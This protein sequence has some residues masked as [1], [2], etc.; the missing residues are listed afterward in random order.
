MRRSRLS[1]LFFS[2]ITSQYAFGNPAVDVPQYSEAHLV[3]ETEAATILDHVFLVDQGINHFDIS[4]HPNEPW[5]CR[6]QVQ[7]VYADGEALPGHAGRFYVE[8]NP[9]ISVLLVRYFIPKNHGYCTLKVNGYRETEPSEIPC[10]ED[11]GCVFEDS[12]GLDAFEQP[13][14]SEEEFRVDRA[15]REFKIQFAS[16]D[17]WIC[18][19]KVLGASANGKSLPGLGSRFYTEAYPNVDMLAVEIFVPQNDGY[20]SLT[21]KGYR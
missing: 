8:G 5:E 12:L 9:N 17:P 7:N 10:S 1:V 2:V 20:C 13:T 16:K 3:E 6:A 21:V 15:I 18:T 14:L 19:S 11:R 4:F